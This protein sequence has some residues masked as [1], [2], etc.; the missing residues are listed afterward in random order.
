M[1]T[2]TLDAA[3][4]PLHVGDTVGGT[5]PLPT[6]DTVVGTVTELNGERITV[7]GDSRWSLPVHRAFL[8]GRPLV[9]SLRAAGFQ[10]AVSGPALFYITPET[11]ETRTVT[12]VDRSA[13]TDARERCVCHALAVHALE[14]G[15]FSKPPLPGVDD[16][17][18][19]IY[20]ATDR[21]SLY[22]VDQQTV[23]DPRERA[24]CRALLK[25][26]RDLAEEPVPL[27]V[28]EHGV[29]QP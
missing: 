16:G 13:P 6:T 10:L 22:R 15:D 19:L 23:E 11:N 26:A 5:L 3:G 17:P 18:A 2:S 20:A 9:G 8:V 28:D 29:I 12:W 21:V 25:I 1:T 7:V 4:R 14:I 24:V 27:R